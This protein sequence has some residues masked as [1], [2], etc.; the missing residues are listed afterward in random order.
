MADVDA[1]VDTLIVDSL[2]DE[3][4]SA[5]AVAG[6][7]TEAPESEADGERTSV[8]SEV[9]TFQHEQP[10]PVE[11]TDAI[12]RDF[13]EAF[14][15]QQAALLQAKWGDKAVHRQ[16]EANALLDANPELRAAVADHENE[17]GYPFRRPTVRRC[18]RI[19]GVAATGSKARSLRPLSSARSMGLGASFPRTL[20]ARARE[21]ALP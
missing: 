4:Y 2:P 12:Y 5:D 20:A 3:D 9:D 19:E 10:M 14:G 17:H 16:A 11:H 8:R 7:I 1:V 13:R 18:R 6:E 21:H 15:D